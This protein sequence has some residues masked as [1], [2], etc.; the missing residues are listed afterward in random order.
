M[1]HTAACYGTG[2]RFEND[3]KG[4][5]PGG[6]VFPHHQRRYGQVIVGIDTL[7]VGG[8]EGRG[9]FAPGVTRDMQVHV[10]G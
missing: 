1:L 7:S 8:G 6:A 9:I 4:I 10:D 2:M 5:V 3:G